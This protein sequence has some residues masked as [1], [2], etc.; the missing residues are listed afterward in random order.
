MIL[1]GFVVNAVRNA[2]ITNKGDAARQGRRGV[3]VAAL[4]AAADAVFLCF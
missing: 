1:A 4:G 2:C 3:Q